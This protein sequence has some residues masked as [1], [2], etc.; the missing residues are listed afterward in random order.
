VNT[1]D[2]D[3]E[4]GEAV[5]RVLSDAGARVTTLRGLVASLNY[6]VEDDTM[7]ALRDTARH[8]LTDPEFGLDAALLSEAAGGDTMWPGFLGALSQIAEPITAGEIVEYVLAPYGIPRSSVEWRTEQIRRVG[9]GKTS[10]YQSTTFVIG[11]PV[12]GL[13]AQLA[14]EV[15]KRVAVAAYFARHNTT[16]IRARFEGNGKAVAYWDEDTQSGLVMINDEIE[17]LTSFDPPWPDWSVRVD[18][19]ESELSGFGHGKQS[20]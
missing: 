15:L 10:G 9:R 5:R 2:L 3:N 4:T 20:A 16:Y 13:S 7:V 1:P 18:E 12:E 14:H 6:A 19:L 11:T 17:D 8:L